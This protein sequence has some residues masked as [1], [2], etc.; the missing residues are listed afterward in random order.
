MES[1]RQQHV[2]KYITYHPVGRD[3]CQHNESILNTKSKSRECAINKLTAGSKWEEEKIKSCAHRTKSS[4]IM[5]GVSCSCSKDAWPVLGSKWQIQWASCLLVKLVCEEQHKFDYSSMMQCSKINNHKLKKEKVRMTQ[6]CDARYKTAGHIAYWNVVH[7]HRNMYIAQRW[8]LRQHWKSRTPEYALA[9]KGI[10]NTEL[11]NVSCT[12]QRG[13]YYHYE[14]TLTGWTSGNRCAATVHSTEP[15][16]K[17]RNSQCSQ[18][19]W[20][21]KLSNHK[22]CS[23]LFKQESRVKKPIATTKTHFLSYKT[24]GKNQRELKHLCWPIPPCI[25]QTNC[26]FIFVARIKLSPCGP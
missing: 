14:R 24:T 7:L 25:L 15:S 23:P 2:R 10:Q 17:P 9:Q 20:H 18:L 16:V 22:C 21:I 8:S 19:H 26:L 5:Q 11:G 4:V 6:D 1:R 12:P 13:Q 3:S